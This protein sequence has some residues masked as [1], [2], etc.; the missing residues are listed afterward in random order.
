MPI[1]AIIPTYNRRESLIDCLESIYNQSVLPKEIIIINNGSTNISDI[2]LHWTE[3][4][5]EK[6]VNCKY[7]KNNIENSLTVAKNIGIDLS[8]EEIIS[9]LDDDL[10]LETDYYKEILLV[11]SSSLNVNGVMGY[12]QDVK[13]QPPRTR[14]EKI[15]KKYTDFFQLSMQFSDNKCRVYPSLSY[16]YPFHHSLHIQTTEWLS[17]ASVFRKKIFLKIRPDTLLKKYSW[18]E[19][20]EMSYRIHKQYPNSLYIT[21]YAKYWHKGS[22]E[23]RIPNY[24][25]IY[26]KEV[27]ALYLFFK[28]FEYNFTNLFS[29]IKRWFGQILF[30]LMQDFIHL[31]KK[32]III[33]I[34]RIKAMV[35]VMKHYREIRTGNIDFFNNRLS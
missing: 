8:T 33:T 13:Y 12:N 34:C 15:M 25:L 22:P 32:R 20:L 23:G 29:Y 35:Y 31:S 1:S 4:F 24:E 28:L 6:E 14:Q 27:Y 9:F 2:L 30:F 26:M 7:F 5:N 16:S 10:I 18:N 19:D 3:K 21:P 17:G 11:F